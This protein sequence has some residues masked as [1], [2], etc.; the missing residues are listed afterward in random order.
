M[1]LNDLNKKQSIK[2]NLSGQ[3]FESEIS[4]PKVMM[5]IVRDKLYAHKLRTPIQE[6]IANAIDS[7][8]VA[9]NESTPLRLVLPTLLEP[10]LK[11]RDFGTGMSEEKVR[12]VFSQYTASDKRENLDLIGGFGLGSKSAFAYTDKFTIVSYYNGIK[13]SYVA[14]A[15]SQ[16]DL[17]FTPLASS[18]TNE[19]NGVEIQIPIK[20]ADISQ[21]IEAVTRM[22]ILLPVCPEMI[23]YPIEFK[24]DIYNN[25]YNA[26]LEDNKNFSVFDSSKIPRDAA[27]ALNLDQ[28]SYFIRYNNIPYL[29]ANHYSY[30]FDRQVQAKC[31]SKLIVMFKA[32]LGTFQ[33]PP[34]REILVEDDKYK[35]FI[36]TKGEAAI[37]WNAKARENERLVLQSPTTLDEMSVA[38]KKIMFEFEPFEKDLFANG[39]SLPCIV[40]ATVSYK[41][42]HS[43]MEVSRVGHKGY[44]SFNTFKNDKF[45]TKVRNYIAP[46]ADRKESYTVYMPCSQQTLMVCEDELDK[47]SLFSLNRL[48]QYFKSKQAIDSI[49]LVK[50]DSPFA[51]IASGKVSEITMPDRAREVPLYYVY[52]DKYN[53]VD[54]KLVMGQTHFAG[55]MKYNYIEVAEGTKEYPLEEWVYSKLTTGD[56]RVIFLPKETVKLLSARKSFEKYFTKVNIK[57]FKTKD[58]RE[59]LNE[60]EL[61][62]VKLF[63]YNLFE[64]VRSDGG[65]FIWSLLKYSLEKD[66]TI[67]NKW[68]MALKK[69]FKVYKELK[70]KYELSLVKNEYSYYSLPDFQKEFEEN[71]IKFIQNYPLLEILRSN[72]NYSQKDAE[73]A[74]V[75][76]YFKLVDQARNTGIL[77]SE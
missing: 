23:N 39:H 64:N 13:H 27:K 69:K 71:R 52:K 62:I 11:I 26:I 58:P 74:M 44:R 30:S 5:L 68:F 19:P 60:K 24:K 61:E 33:I 48:K 47:V 16:L 59:N 28:N 20:P 42:K 22:V 25:F 18:K 49:I 32:P 66:L 36:S 6:Y 40:G 7:Q 67:K 55:K 21:A 31:K 50:P 76:D 43:V 38:I 14:Y 9:K 54:F 63:N 35:N 12:K 45:T 1:K 72:L 56:Q 4:D 3:S 70:E 34:S 77:K 10:T 65:K 29:I 73:S 41:I 46:T 15:P 2:S 57:E 51:G 75:F 37:E 53:N 17:V 8:I